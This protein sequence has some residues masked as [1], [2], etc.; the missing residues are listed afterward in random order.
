MAPS[1]NRP[2]LAFVDVARVVAMLLMVQGHVCDTLLLPAL[3]ETSFFA[4]Y[5][6]FRGLTAPLFF[7]LAG[8]AFVIASDSSW[9]ALRSPGPKLTARLRRCVALMAA[10]FFLQIPRWHGWPPF[11]LTAEEWR[12]V[13][14]CN[15]LH[16]VALSVLF[17]HG[18]MALTGT[19]RTFTLAAI[20]CGLLAILL[21]PPLTAMELPTSL[22]IVFAL[23]VRTNEGSLFPVFPWL[24][25]FLFGATLARLHLDVPALA[26]ARR[27]GALLAVAGPLLLAFGSLCRALDP[28]RVTAPGYWTTD[29]SLVMTRAGGAWC[30]IAAVAL[31][32]GK[33]Q[34]S[35]RL[36][37]EISA[38][39][40]SVYVLHLMILWG[41][42]TLPGLVHR[43]GPTLSLAQAFCM[44]PL[45]LAASAAISI[46]AAQLL[47]AL[48]RRR[49]GLKGRVPG[50]DGGST[51]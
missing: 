24:A 22:P 32:F 38:R 33:L 17:T 23:V 27:L 20:G 12:Y 39:S 7:A 6:T 9:E 19:R 40:L 15:V 42:P 1:S 8:F 4:G 18:L 41:P 49:E 16:C 46:A 2:R 51:A 14:R 11:D 48:Q 37:Q 34:T 44:G 30:F 3:K 5:W 47:A 21:A 36:L 25:H 50:L 45:V 35:P 29:A 26:T 28:A 13:L 10:G 31:L 43:V